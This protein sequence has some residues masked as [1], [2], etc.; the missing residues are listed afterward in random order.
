M[1]ASVSVSTDSRPRTDLRTGLP[2]SPAASRHRRTP[3]KDPRLFVGIALVAASA[4]LGAT[5][6][7]G[8]S[9]VGVWATRTALTEG[10]PVAEDDLVRREVRFAEQRDA[11]RYLPADQ[12]LP[13]GASVSHDVGAGELLP[14]SAVR[15]GT[16]EPLIE[17]PLSVA[18]TAVPVTVRVG[19]VVDV[20]VV[21]EVGAAA[22]R[23]SDP[24]P[25]AR[26]VLPDVTVL[27]LSR[28]TGPLGAG[29]ERQ[30]VVGLGPELQG[31]LPVALGSMAAGSVVLTSTR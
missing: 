14:R 6:L 29:A 2:G 23:G 25:T 19:S 24:G 11:D 9:G 12:P 30:V 7:G 20:W 26:R 8:E 17:V 22:P 27:H 13:D 1:M 31:A 21:P 3:W 28:A 4:L 15:T 5:L 16:A 10:Q 18:P